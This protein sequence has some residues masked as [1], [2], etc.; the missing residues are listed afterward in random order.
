MPLLGDFCLLFALALVG[1]CLIAGIAAALL[2]KDAT[3]S[4]LAETARR[5]GMASAVAVTAAALALVWSALT[6]DF[7]VSYILHHSNRALPTPYKLAALWSGQE[8]SLLFWSWLLAGYGFV[9]RL[10]HRVDRQL[11]AMTSTVLAG[12]QLF[13]LILVNFPANPFGIMD[14]VAAD[15]NGLN[16]LLQYPEMVIHPPMLY[17]G[18]VGFSVPFAF[19]LAALIL[20]YPGEKWIHITRRWTMVTWLFLTCGIFL[21]A[22]WAYAVLGWGGYWGWDPVEIASLL[23]WLTG[24]AFLHSV[25]MQEKRGM[26]KIWNVWLIFITFMLSI[27]GTLMTRS[28]IVSSVHAFAQS[29]IGSWFVTFLAIIFG[30]CLAAYLKNRSHLESE[31]KLQSLVS[32]ESSF[33]FNNVVLLG[34]TFA[35]LCG[36]LFPIFSEWV[37]GY[38]ITVGA[39]FF[40]KITIPIGLFL[41]FLTGFGPL[42]AWGSTSFA[43]IRRNFAIPGLI[44]VLL[45]GVLIA[46]GMRPWTQISVFYSWAAFV[47][48]ALVVATIASEFVRGGRVLQGK[49]NTNIFGAMYHLTRRNM[50]RYGGYVVHFGV[51]VIAVGI[52]GLAFNQDHE[53]EMGLG[54]TLKLGHYTLVGQE[55]TQDDNANYS[56]EAATLD[57][58]RDGKYLTRLN[59]ELRFFKASGGQP[60]HI[61]AN[62]S[63]YREDL[64]VIYEGRNPD[65]GHPIIKAF[66][67]PLVT[68]VWIGVFIIIFGTGLALVP[69][70]AAVRAAVP[71]PVMVSVGD[72]GI[73]TPVGARK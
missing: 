47:I 38:K 73:L 49:L 33:L 16:P 41:I 21:G 10:R 51:V 66:V 43:S 14:R 1:Y 3:G 56:S 72:Q 60:D 7:S 9:L 44:A 4:W 50:R 23:P 25:M 20:R 53:Q 13:F 26:M 39:P 36:T 61:V 8:G 64:Y 17:L 11:V 68:W 42:L 6:N 5:A 12:V 65:T 28:G 34:A 19:A 71:A 63:T 32:R 37:R 46:L 29:S 45:G 22:H 40:N 70:A 54:D 31:N 55:Y 15:G 35:L 58:Y 24:T 48:S 59:P 30:V 57:V 18:Y 2:R 62:H 27:L 69:N 52:A 67:N